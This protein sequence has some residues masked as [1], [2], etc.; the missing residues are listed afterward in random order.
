VTTY[1]L[2]TGG[3]YT[4][5]GMATAG[6]SVAVTG[7]HPNLYVMADL[8][9]SE[10]AAAFTAGPCEWSALYIN[11]GGKP[12]LTYHD[13]G[14]TKTGGGGTFKVIWDTNGAYRIKITQ[15]A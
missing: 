13:F 6:M 11:S 8:T 2:E 3:G 9:D 10:W 14:A 12:L 5:G 4:A 1:E 7:T 15:A